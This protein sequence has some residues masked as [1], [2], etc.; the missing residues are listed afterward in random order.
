M[1]GILQYPC[2]MSFN[3]TR[4][5]FPAAR[6]LV[7]CSTV[8]LLLSAEA[9]NG[10]LLSEASGSQLTTPAVARVPLAAT[11][12]VVPGVEV[13]PPVKAR[14]PRRKAVSA[15]AHH[16]VRRPVKVRHRRAARTP[17]AAKTST[18]RPHVEC[19]YFEPR[20][21][22]VEP[23]A[24]EMARLMEPV[25]TD[26]VAI[27]KLLQKRQRRPRRHRPEPALP[28]APEPGTW[29]MMVSG[30]AAVGIALRRRRLSSDGGDGTE[31]RSG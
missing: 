1:E 9:G 27:Q 31:A 2:C 4:L 7:G 13:V 30:F 22:T 5:S 24:D 20:I 14:S 29:L 25:A 6:F 18:P 15:R 16:Q 3:V 28:A 12:W 11:C 10:A 19:F 23:F 17:L 8:L 21:V 26:D